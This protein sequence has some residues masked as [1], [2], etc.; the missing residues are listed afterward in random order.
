MCPHFQKHWMIFLSHSLQPISKLKTQAVSL[1]PPA[2]EIHA[3][4]Q[5]YDIMTMQ[6][7]YQSNLIIKNYIHHIKVGISC[8]CLWKIH[9]NSSICPGIDTVW[10]LRSY[11]KLFVISQVE[12]SLTQ[13]C[14]LHTIKPD[15]YFSLCIRML[16]Y[17]TNSFFF[18]GV[19]VI[20]FHIGPFPL[21][22]SDLCSF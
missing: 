10:V 11:P 13:P 17:K 19:L 4:Y 12:H 7:Y 14:L 22:D 1:F 18:R 16:G 2:G 21:I 9:V 15:I 8:P 20:S 6:P 5:P 3:K